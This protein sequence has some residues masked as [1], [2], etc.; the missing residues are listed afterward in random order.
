M[1]DHQQPEALDRAGDAEMLADEGDLIHLQSWQYVQKVLRASAI[2]LRRLHE[3]VL[4]LEAAR[5]AYANEFPLN[6]DGE[7][8]V[9]NIHANIRKLKSNI[10]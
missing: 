2:E 4:S 3:R 1:N 9:E 5:I 6:K 10:K 7:P 8:D